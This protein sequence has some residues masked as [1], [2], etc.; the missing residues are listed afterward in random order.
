MCS[1]RAGIFHSRS[2]VK[3][4]AIKLDIK[5][6]VPAFLL[7]G[8]NLK[9]QGDRHKH[10]VGFGCAVLRG[11]GCGHRGWVQ[12]LRTSA[13]QIG[14]SLQLLRFFPM[15]SDSQPFVRVAV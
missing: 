4:F 5:A 10:P 8:K 1:H 6:L 13:E 14:C 12:I 9:T 3:L 7:C 15:H 2:S 11:P